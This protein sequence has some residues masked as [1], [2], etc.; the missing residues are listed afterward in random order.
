MSIWDIN[1][2]LLLDIIV[3]AE[4][5]YIYQIWSS[6][7]APPGFVKDWYNVWSDINSQT[8]RKIVWVNFASVEWATWYFIQLYN[9]TSQSLVFDWIDVWNITSKCVISSDFVDETCIDA[10]KNF[11]LSTDSVYQWRVQAYND[12][13]SSPTSLS[14]WFYIEE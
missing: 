8:E 11:Y 12:D 2:D 7:I 6:R 13:I 1:G 10:W 4:D 5:W 14:N 9:Y 3:S